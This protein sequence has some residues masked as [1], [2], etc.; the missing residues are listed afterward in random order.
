MVGSR[1]LDV[2]PVSGEPCVEV[3]PI[4][5]GLTS[6]QQVEVARFARPLTLTAGEAVFRAGEASPRLFVVHEG[7]VKISRVS[8]AGRET[9]LR[10]LGPGGVAG[11][12]SFVTGTA[13]E[14]DA[15][16]LVP[17]R[18]CVFEHRD[19]AVLVGRF[20]EIGVGMLRALG[21]K[22]AAVERMVTSLTSADVGARIAAYLLDCPARWDASGRPTVALP[23][24]KKD[25]AKLLG[26]TPETLS[27]RLAEFERDGLI[28]LLP[29]RDVVILDAAGL[30]GRAA[31]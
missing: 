10:V 12:V 30:A 17:S 20:P 8:A 4:F 5:A 16:A 23:L 31:D 21:S 28:R 18:M 29:G 22:L 13:P 11:E 26:T 15:V 19:L 14:N 24:A 25:V 3:V 1:Q 27:R 7:Q 2:R 9:I 6:A